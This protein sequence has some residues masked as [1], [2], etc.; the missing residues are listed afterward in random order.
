MLEM[1][2]QRILRKRTQPMALYMGN[3]A[4]KKLSS[5]CCWKIPPSFTRISEIT[6]SVEERED[7]FEYCWSFS[8]CT[9][10][11]VALERYTRN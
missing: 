6:P 2:R 8:D 9:Y 7:Y 11:P 3:L 1:K 5:N 4:P 10:L